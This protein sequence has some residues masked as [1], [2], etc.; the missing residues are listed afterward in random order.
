MLQFLSPAVERRTLLVRTAARLRHAR[1]P[2]SA[3]KAPTRGSKRGGR[4]AAGRGRGACERSSSSSVNGQF[5]ERRHGRSLLQ[6]GAAA[7]RDVGRMSQAPRL[8]TDWIASAPTRRS[9]TAG[10]LTMTASHLLAGFEAADPRGTIQRAGGV[11]RARDAATSSNVRPIPKHASV[12]TKG[13]DGER[14]P[15]G[16]TS[17]ASATATPTSISI[18]AGAKRPSCK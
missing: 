12:I 13:I 10:P 15:P 17:V 16:L 14:P 18:R 5:G 8:M 9:S 11:D 3:A 6:C 1:R 4:S 2:W 7:F